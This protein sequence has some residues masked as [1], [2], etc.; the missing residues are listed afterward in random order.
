[1]IEF[2]SS[3]LEHRLVAILRSVPDDRLEPVADALAESGVRLVEI[4]LSDA[5]TL[6][7]IESLRS[8]L[9]ADVQVGAG[10]VTT[11][12]LAEAAVASG[13]TFLV[14]PHVAEDVVRFAVRRS[15]GL[16]CGVMTPTEA[17]RARELG[18][19]FLKLFPAVSLGPAYVR[20]LL[21]PFPDLELFP[22]GG[23][24][25]GNLS[26]FLEAGA[27]GAGVGG[28]LSK[29]TPEEIRAETSRLHK[30]LRHRPDLELL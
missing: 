17:M 5:S 22:T 7:Q 26:A 10:T 4:A 6:G 3:L 18:A 9:P 8:F 15:L 24:S 13:A 28:A 25:S 21:G 14:T 16:L 27:V 30:I 12:E 2:G 19:R 20:Q 29:G 23:I 1:M 11:V